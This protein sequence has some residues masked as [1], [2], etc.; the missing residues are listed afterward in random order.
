MATE[1][2]L[3]IIRR[4]LPTNLRYFPIDISFLVLL[5]VV[6]FSQFAIAQT[7]MDIGIRLNPAL[8]K[9]RVMRL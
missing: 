8:L 1:P 7:L 5:G 6:V 3:R 4:M 9:E 2:V